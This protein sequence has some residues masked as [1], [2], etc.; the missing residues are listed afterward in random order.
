MEKPFYN[1]PRLARWMFEHLIPSENHWYVSGDLDEIY[2]DICLEKNRISAALWYW[3]QLFISLPEILGYS[4]YWSLAMI[5]NYLILFFRNLWRHPGFSFI[6]IVG[7]AVGM[8]ASLL[9]T[10]WVAD[11]LSYDRFHDHAETLYRIESEVTY[12]GGTRHTIATPPPLALV[13]A[14]EVPEV[15]RASHCTR[16]GGM[17]IR[18]GD[19]VFFE[20]FIHAVNPTFFDMFSFPLLIGEKTTALRDPFSIVLT[21]ETAEKLFGEEDPMDKTVLVENQWEMTVRGIIGKPPSNSTIQFDGLVRYEFARD[22]LERMPYGWVNAIST[23]A[24]LQEGVDVGLVGKKITDLVHRHAEKPNATY[25]LNPLARLR[26]HTSMGQGR[27]TGLV[28][29]VYIFS[30]VALFVLFIACINF[31]NLSTAR[32]IQRTREIGIRKVVGGRRSQ[33]IRQ[34][35]GESFSFTCIALFL[36]LFLV[37]VLLPVFNGVAFKQFTLAVLL[38]GRL[39]VG[40]MLITVLTALF[41]GIYPSIFM[42]KFNPLS[43]I[44]GSTHAGRRRTVLRKLL[45]IIQFSLS[46]FLII[47]ALVV[48][49]QIRYMKSTDVGYDTENVMSIRMSGNAPLNYPRLRNEL[50]RHPGVLDVTACGRRPTFNADRGDR[51]DWDGKDPNENVNVVFH[52]VDFGYGEMMGMELV[53]GRHYSS[54]FSTDSTS[55]FM[56]NESLARL[57]GGGESAMGKRFKIFWFE[58]QII[59]VVKDFHHMPLRFEIEPVVLLMAPNPYWLSTLLIKISPDNRNQTIEKIESTW[60]NINPAFPFEYTFLDDEFDRMYRLE[61]RTGKLL[62]YSTL[63]AIFI[64]CLGLFGMAAYAAVQRTKEVGIRKASGATAGSLVL[65][66]TRDFVKWVAIANVLAWPAAYIVMR[67]WLNGFVYRTRLGWDIFFMAGTLAI[68]IA[69]LT[70]STQAIRAARTNP[71]DALRYE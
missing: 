68:V 39:L 71:V 6:N 2:N 36:S 4:I 19:K 11:E 49:R 61:E 26:L 18:N 24:Q 42:S 31:V 12:T 5:K 52:T 35:F 33:I 40:I 67:N 65:M 44:R 64:A 55:A 70:V 27:E 23:F 62:A 37:A 58:G 8:A 29:Y 47:G 69:I 13:L 7:L 16:F 22:Q 14:D 43:I 34:F 45:V 50:I 63:L 15:S 41:A 21:E 38:R 30:I 53:E 59:G 28:R 51:I 9:I 48:S 10:L 3:A 57:I 20:N 25:R 32:S 17:H 1:P 56:I 60:K 54:D 66:F 46:V